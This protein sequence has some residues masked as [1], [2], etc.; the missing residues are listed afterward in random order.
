MKYLIRTYKL[1]IH[2]ASLNSSD[3]ANDD[4]DQYM[5]WGEFKE[6]T[7]MMVWSNSTLA[8]S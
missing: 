7:V 5:Y 6:T 1:R 4:D 2:I 8:P 3:K